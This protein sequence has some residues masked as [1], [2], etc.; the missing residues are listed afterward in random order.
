MN[1]RIPGSWLELCDLTFIEG[2]VLL[3]QLQ[4]G[5]LMLHLLEAQKWSSDCCLR[6]LL[7]PSRVSEMRSSLISSSCGFGCEK[8]TRGLLSLPERLPRPIWI[9]PE[10]TWCRS[11]FSVP[12]RHRGNMNQHLSTFRENN[13]LKVLMV[14]IIAK[15]AMGQAKLV[16]KP[17]YLTI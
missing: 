3:R 17:R 14:K 1:N 9:D 13:Q 7:Q 2:L 5:A 6:L 8:Y 15:M 10:L 11:S 12:M 4:K 16:T